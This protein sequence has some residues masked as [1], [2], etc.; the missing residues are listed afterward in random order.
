MINDV[1]KEPV[2]YIVNKNK[3]QEKWW[4]E[5]ENERKPTQVLVPPIKNLKCFR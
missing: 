3:T 2:I 5:R 1:L 4:D